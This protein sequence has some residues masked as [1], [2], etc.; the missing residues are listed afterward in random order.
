M[1]ALGP[2]DVLVTSAGAAQRTPAPELTA[3]HW[4]AADAG[5]IFTGIHA[6]QAVLRMAARGGG[7]VAN[8]VGMGGGW[9]RRT[10]CRVARP[11]RP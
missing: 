10:T 11:M 7:S 1:A 6:P 5:Q 8:I 4:A 2:I 9:R 3:A